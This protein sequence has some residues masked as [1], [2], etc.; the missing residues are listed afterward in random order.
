MGK[1]TGDSAAEGP[2]RLE[3]FYTDQSL[4]PTKKKMTFIM[5]VV[6]TG[7]MDKFQPY[8][9]FIQNPRKVSTRLPSS[10]ARI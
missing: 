6:S 7:T 8:C 1:G 5:M 9:K 4:L 3:Q 2:G 10:R